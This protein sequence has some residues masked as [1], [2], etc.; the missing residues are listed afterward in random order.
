MLCDYLER[1]ETVDVWLMKSNFMSTGT[2][3]PS[4]SKTTSPLQLENDLDTFMIVTTMTESPD[5]VIKTMAAS[6]RRT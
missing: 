4:P 5:A 1:V 3:V 2:S 6:R